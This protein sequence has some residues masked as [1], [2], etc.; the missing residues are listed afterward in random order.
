[1]F[2]A[3]ISYDDVSS[4]FYD[5]SHSSCGLILPSLILS[6]CEGAFLRLLW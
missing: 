3:L 5:V 4:S 6:F 2:D 1:V